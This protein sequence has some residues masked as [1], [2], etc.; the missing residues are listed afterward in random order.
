MPTEGFDLTAATLVGPGSV[1]PQG[2]D[3]TVT[4]DQP[5]DGPAAVL[6]P[7]R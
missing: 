3:L 7:R 2:G 4:L 5:G 6:L 1:Q